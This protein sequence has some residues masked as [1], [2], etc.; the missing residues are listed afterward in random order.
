[1]AAH[2][3]AADII[4]EDDPG[5]ATPVFRFHE[6]GA[7]QHIRTAR[8]VDNRGAKAVKLA[9]KFIAPQI[10]RARAQ[11]RA[12]DHDDSRGFTAGV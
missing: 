6:Q 2:S 7:H 5:G 10:Q 9:L 8:L 4:E 1:M 3:K 11:F 12:A